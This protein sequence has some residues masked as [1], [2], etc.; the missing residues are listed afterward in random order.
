MAKDPEHDQKVLRHL[1]SFLDRNDELSIDDDG[2]LESIWDPNTQSVGKL[3]IRSCLEEM[4]ENI[5]DKKMRIAKELEPYKDDAI[6]VLVEAMNLDLDH[7]FMKCNA[8]DV[9]E[10]IGDDRAIPLILDK[11]DELLEAGPITYLLKA[12]ASREGG[13]TRLLIIDRLIK[14]LLK[15]DRAVSPLNTGRLDGK[16]WDVINTLT[17]LDG[18][19]DPRLPAALEKYIERSAYSTNSFQIALIALSQ[20]NPLRAVSY[21]NAQM[22]T[23]DGD[24]LKSYQK[25]ARSIG[26]DKDNASDQAVLTVCVSEQNDQ[27]AGETP[28]AFKY[29]NP[30]VYF[31][32]NGED[33]TNSRQLA[34]GAESQ[35]DA[36][37]VAINYLGK[38]LPEM[39]VPD[40]RYQEC[41]KLLNE[42]LDF[43]RW[44][45]RQSYILPKKFPLIIYDSQWCRVKF[46]FDH[47][48][49][50]DDR[51]HL[52]VYYGRLHAPSD[53]SFM[54]WNDEKCWCWHRVDYA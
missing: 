41:N 15:N 6:P 24:A 7:V 28:Y 12:I 10:I 33:D 31:L 3:K 14:Y 49:R 4:L 8:M 13:K 20:I 2:K 48:D 46:S 44:G 38:W 1:L 26:D 18:L 35:A 9:L 25:I 43:E 21:L 27:K 36:V 23:I 42:N 29:Q 16:I 5:P 30:L 39:K 52:S 45:F 34:G 32:A 37:S 50:Y 11:F 40:T 54:V 19:D 17:E 51:A 53:D 22:K 47:G